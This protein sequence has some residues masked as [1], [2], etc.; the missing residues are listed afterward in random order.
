MACCIVLFTSVI[1]VSYVTGS[2]YPLKNIFNLSEDIEIA[3]ENYLCNLNNTKKMINTFKCCKCTKD[4]M[5]IK[6]VA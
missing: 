5:R 4:C 6:A 3:K 1:Y 2:K